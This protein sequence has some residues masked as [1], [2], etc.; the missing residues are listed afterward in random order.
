MNIQRYRMLPIPYNVRLELRAGKMTE[1]TFGLMS[2]LLERK[3]SNR[4]TA[5][6]ALGHP[7]VTQSGSIGYQ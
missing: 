3:P 6:E 7:W 4:M 2:Q 1:E 5:K